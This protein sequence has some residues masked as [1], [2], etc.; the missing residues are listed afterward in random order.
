[1]LAAL[2][3]TVVLL[4]GVY[5]C[6]LGVASL[7]WPA[8]AG[9]FLLGFAS[10]PRVHY[11]ELSI[12]FLVGAALILHAPSMFAPT[13]VMFFGW[14]LVITTTC[15][16]LIPWRWHHWFAQRA[17]PRAIP[18]LKAIGICSLVLGGLIVADVIRGSV[19]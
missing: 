17:V 11:I 2:A 14:I 4:T 9:R 5:F 15:I 8:K 3:L 1:M 16:L 7:L 18:H 12:R 6:A 19:V 13:P 10:S